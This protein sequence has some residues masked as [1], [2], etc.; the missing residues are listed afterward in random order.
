MI[1]AQNITQADD[2]HV[3]SSVSL[4]LAKGRRTR[5][6]V[7]TGTHKMSRTTKRAM[8]GTVTGHSKAKKVSIEINKIY[9]MEHLWIVLKI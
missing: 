3:C 7:L 6:A 1:K 8:V 4:S 5:P 9:Q 2:C